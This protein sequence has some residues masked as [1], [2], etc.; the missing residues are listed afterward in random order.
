M[1]AIQIIKYGDARS[2]F[3]I[4]EIE[5]PAMSDD[6]VLIENEVS[7]LNFADVVARLGQYDAAPPLPSIIGY[8]VVGKII[9]IGKNVKNV[10]VG[11]RV[12]AMTRFGGY[13]QFSV[14]NALAC[15]KI[16]NE[17]NAVEACALTTQYC[18]A[19][20]TAEEMIKLH[21]GDL[22]LIH[23]AAGGVGTAL[24]QIAKHYR[25][26]IFATVGSDEKVEYLKSIGV[27][28]PINYL[29]NN[30]KDEVKKITKSETPLDV[31]FDAIGGANFRKGV[32]LLNAGG[33]MVAYGASSMTD[34]KNKFTQ[35][36]AGLQFGIFHPAQWLIPSRSLIGVN[37]LA[38]ADKNQKML[39]R[40][41]VDVA[42][43][44]QSGIY[45]PVVA[46]VFQADKIAEAHEF[47]Q[48]RKSIG[49]IAIQWR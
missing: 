18:T 12:T 49:K 11:D 15:A 40:I 42:Q 22:V 31:V 8:D 38:I 14:T 2:A 24:V 47:M 26:E 6:Q 41:L 3:R 27:Q 35:L 43:R 37:M 39:Q 20:F 34:A 36:Y 23:A 46:K 30:F 5:K 21:E 13:A 17:V 25:C 4:V 28:H 32:S 48:S 44:Y 1:K 33:R 45:K 19:H 7:G 9:S 10:K 16:P 29:K